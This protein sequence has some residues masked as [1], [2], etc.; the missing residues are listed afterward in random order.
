MTGAEFPIAEF[1]QTSFREPMR[2]DFSASE[3][4]VIVYREERGADRLS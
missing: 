1:R 4:G 2:A 3:R